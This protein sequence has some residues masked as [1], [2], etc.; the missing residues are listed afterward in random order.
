MLVIILLLK[1]RKT[2]RE[3]EHL[4]NMRTSELLE[5]TKALELQTEKAQV[6][7]RAKSEFLARMSHEIRTP[8]SAIIGMTEI[9]KKAVAE[10]KAMQSLASVTTAST[11]LLGL[12]NDILDMS[13]IESGKFVLNEEAFDF[14]RAMNEVAEMIAQRCAEKNIRF[15]QDF[16]IQE[17]IGV[18]GDRLRLKQILVNLLGN[19]VKFTPDNGTITMSVVTEKGTGGRI[20]RRQVYFKR[21]YE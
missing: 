8:L 20:Q 1:N 10:P 21:L 16:D 19:A 11:H 17:A 12:L 15:I 2:G 4:V 5:R 9:A 3:L 14:R 7:T 6:A 18:L 13:K